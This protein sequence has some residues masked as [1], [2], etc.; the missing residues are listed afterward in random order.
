MVRQSSYE[1]NA[2]MA[3]AANLLAFGFM[4]GMVRSLNKEVS[5][6]YK[7][8]TLQSTLSRQEVVG[9]IR[10][11][12]LKMPVEEAIK[13]FQPVPGGSLSESELADIGKWVEKNRTTQGPQSH[14]DRIW[15]RV[16]IQ[17]GK[18]K[19]SPATYE[20]II[21]KNKKLLLENADEFRRTFGVV[22]HKFMS[23]ITGFDIVRF[24]DFLGT[25]EGISTRDYI[26]RKY[27]IKAVR[28]IERLIK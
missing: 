13:M 9:R 22:L 11:L 1:D 20:D 19:D 15:E 8:K 16:K 4:M 17:E 12:S 3:L 5:T 18:V 23:P 2:V 26:N 10:I 24:D 21:G 27:G 25:P 7:T 14:E 6:G 28:L